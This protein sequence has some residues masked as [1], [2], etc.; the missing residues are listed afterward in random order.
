MPA[1]EPHP[2]FRL[3]PLAFPVETDMRFR[4]L[5][6]A[7]AGTTFGLAN[8]AIYAVLPSS[9]ADTTAKTIST[10]GAIAI[11]LLLF[12]IAHQRAIRAAQALVTRERWAPF[13]PP[14]GDAL[15]QVSLQRMR[16]HVDQ[17]I[18]ALPAVTAQRLQLHWNDSSPDHL[19]TAGMAFGYRD[20]Q[21]L[22]LNEG[23]HAAFL[24]APHTKRFHSVLLH[25]LAHVTNRDVSRTTFSIELGR[26]FTQLVPRH[27]V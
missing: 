8:Y 13:P 2:A 23:M 19:E 26:T 17:I 27:A 5:L 25:E 20:R 7:A 14:S 22:C 3:N 4:L 24:S 9:M 16:T 6:I 12:G 18:R 21:H 15:E 11:V 1:S 10:V